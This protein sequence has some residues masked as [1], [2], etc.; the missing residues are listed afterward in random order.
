MSAASADPLTGYFLGSFG[1]HGPEVLHLQRGLLDGEEALIAHKVTGARPGQLM[2][3]YAPILEVMKPEHRRSRTQSRTAWSV[4]RRCQQQAELLLLPRIDAYVT[5]FSA[6]RPRVAP[7]HSR[8]LAGDPHVPASQVSFRAKIGPAHR[9]STDGYPSQM[10]VAARFV[11]EGCVAEEGFAKPTWCCGEL[12][13][14]GPRRSEQFQRLTGNA[15]LGFVWN[16]VHSKRFLI[17]LS[18]LDFGERAGKE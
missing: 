12:L 3:C 16:M 13:T 4:L 6:Y 11:G 7:D 10:D 17:L 1:K 15:G 8:T 18:R 5:T 9:Q 2:T 14:F